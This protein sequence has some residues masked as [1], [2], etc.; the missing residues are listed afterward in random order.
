MLADP[1]LINWLAEIEEVGMGGW[2]V[3]SWMLERRC[4]LMESW[5]ASAGKGAP[6]SLWGLD[7]LSHGFARWRL[8]YG[9]LRLSIWGGIGIGAGDVLGRADEKKPIHF[10][11]AYTLSLFASRH[12]LHRSLRMVQ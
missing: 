9:R 12:A 7:G 6:I 1:G 4:W 5:T 8:C 10:Y 2:L 11:P 3:L